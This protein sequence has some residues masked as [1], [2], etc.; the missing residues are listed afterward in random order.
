[1]VSVWQHQWLKAVFYLFNLGKYRFLR[2]HFRL[3]HWVLR[4][5][6]WTEARSYRRRGRWPSPRAIGCVSWWSTWTGPPLCQRGPNTSSC[7]CPQSETQTPSP[8]SPTKQT[9]QSHVILDVYKCSHKLPS[10]NNKDLLNWKIWQRWDVHLSLSRR[11][12]THLDTGTPT[13]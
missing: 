7:R 4:V 10:W 13:P 11:I 3:F 5:P 12:D 1:M 9:T 6:T 2:C 8:R